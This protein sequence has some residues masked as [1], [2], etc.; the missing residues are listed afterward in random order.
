ME[1][2]R[3]KIMRGAMEG[4][5]ESGLEGL[6]MKTVSALSGC[7]ASTIYTLFNGKEHLLR[8]CFEKVD[9][10]I[11]GLFW[12]ARLDPLALAEDP[13]GE[14]RRHW[15][16]Y[17]RFLVDHPVET[18]FYVRYRGGSRFAA[19][20]KT[21]DISHFA[22]FMGIVKAFDRQYHVFEGVPSD[23]V[24]LHLLTTTLMYARYVVE[25]ILPRD[26]ATQERIFQIEMNGL[27]SLM[28]ADAADGH[29]ERTGKEGNLNAVAERRE[30]VGLPV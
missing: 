3:E 27:R 16:R 29:G 22:D 25:G 13:E 8:C 9:H 10:Q 11:A 1:D 14:L 28:A 2:K 24:W 18:L 19:Y 7:N 4:V 6:N 23:L 17:F 20:D 30:P 12:R 5:A 15:T 21:R 26:A